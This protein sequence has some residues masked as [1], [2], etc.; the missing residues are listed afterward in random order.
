MR[1]QSY[2]FFYTPV[3]ITEIYHGLNIYFFKFL[4]EDTEICHLQFVFIIHPSIGGT[5]NSQ[6]NI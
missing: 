1:L 6:N 3:M 4:N 2:C 5:F